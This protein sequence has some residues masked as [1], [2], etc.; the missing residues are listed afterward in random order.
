MKLTLFVAALPAASAAPTWPWTKPKPLKYPGLD[1]L[2]KRAGLD[3]FGTAIDNVVLDNK[4]YT[5]IA[6]NRSEFGQVTPSN[7]QKWMYIGPTRNKFNYTLGDQ[8]TKPATRNRQLKRCHNFVWHNQ[9]PEWLTSGNWTKTELIKIMENHIKNEARHY[10]NDCFAWDV[11]N[12]AFEDD[13]TATLRKSIW[14]N[15]IGPEYIE[16]AFKF[17][18][19]YTKPGTKLYYND[20]AIERV[21]NKSRAVETLA[22]DFIKRR[23]PIDGIGLQAHYTVGRAP[24]YDEQKATHK[25]FNK[26]GLETSLTE[27][28]VRIQLPDNA[29]TQ[30]LQGA[31]YANSTKACLDAKDCVGITVWDFW[32][33]VS[34]VPDTFPGFGNACIWDKDFKKKP[35]Y[36]AV[37]DLLR[38][39]A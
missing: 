4:Q 3:Y 32:D 1:V 20:Y 19:K 6:N 13:A 12:E 8:I 39:Y 23:I 35:A 37:A 38:S 10:Y 26:L 24:T 11:V 16:L 22:K 5:S 31:V 21:N 30:A 7:G 33:P 17:A 14:L 34:W 2:A 27:L 25:M 29:T 18:R 28:D 36:Y 15:V 9:L